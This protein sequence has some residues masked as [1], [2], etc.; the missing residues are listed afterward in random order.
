MCLFFISKSGLLDYAYA[1]T[2]AFPAHGIVLLMP[3]PPLAHTRLHGVRVGFLKS[4]HAFR[5]QINASPF[6]R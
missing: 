4:G 3:P 5:G 6:E 1:R 2:A